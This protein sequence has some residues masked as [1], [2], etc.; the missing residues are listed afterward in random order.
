MPGIATD[1]EVAALTAARG[2]EAETLFLELM[3]RHHQGGIHMASAA[4][5]TAA[6]DFVRKLAGGMVESQQ[7]EIDYMADLLAARGVGYR[8]D[9]ASTPSPSDAGE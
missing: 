2:V 3:I 4:A 7:A 1:D 9:E 8:G 6:T 5:S